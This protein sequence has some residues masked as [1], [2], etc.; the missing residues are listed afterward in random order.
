MARPILVATHRK[1]P[2]SS[3]IIDQLYKK[4]QQPYVINTDDICDGSSQFTFMFSHDEGHLL[5]DSWSLPISAI[6]SAWYWRAIVQTSNADVRRK[7]A[8]EREMYKTL[9]GVWDSIDDG[10]WLNPPHLIKQT[11]NKIMQLQHAY[12]AGLFVIPTVA[13]N[14]WSTIKSEMPDNFIVKMPGKGLLEANIATNVLYTTAI[15]KKDIAGLKQSSPFPG[16]YQPFLS[17]KKEW[18]VTIVGEKV[19]AAAIYTNN[20][21]K[22]DWRLHAHEKE[23]VHFIAEDFPAETA[24][25]CKEL[26]QKLG[27]RYG[28]FDFIQT[29]D[30]QLYFVEVNSNGQYLWLEQALGFPISEAIAD[31]LIAIASH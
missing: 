4:N 7:A 21:S 27:L 3:A 15:H 16:M 2:V 20:R 10:K 9:N 30:D 13:T 6:A 28:A 24:K 29:E 25:K 18:R 12:A 5:Y 17:K 22:D 1:N 23:A 14:S 31:E 19:F 26:L 8:I 11:Q